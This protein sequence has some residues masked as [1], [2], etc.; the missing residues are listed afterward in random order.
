MARG[1]FTKSKMLLLRREMSSGLS[2]FSGSK[3]QTTESHGVSKVISEK[4][5]KEDAT[6]SSSSSSSSSCWIPHPKTG[7]YFPKGHEW[8]MNDVPEG[9]ATFTQTCWFRNDDGVDYPHHYN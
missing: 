7:I 9:A 6:S 8:V 2:K 5:K 4:K 3:A 1:G